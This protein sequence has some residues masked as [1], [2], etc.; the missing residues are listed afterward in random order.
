MAP[1]RTRKRNKPTCD[2]FTRSILSG[3]EKVSLMRLDDLRYN[4]LSGEAFAWYRQYLAALDAKDVQA[5]AAFL[6]PGI[7]MRF[8]SEPALHGHAGV[9]AALAGIG[10]A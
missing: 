6:A 3:H 1:I 10:R 4:Q 7:E 8:N 5:F 9:T 2:A